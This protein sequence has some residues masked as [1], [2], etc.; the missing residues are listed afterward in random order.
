MSVCHHQNY[1]NAEKEVCW[2]NTAEIYHL[3][4]LS[5]RVWQVFVLINFTVTTCIVINKLSISFIDS[6]VDLLYNNTIET[7]SCWRK[8]LKYFDDHE[9]SNFP[10]LKIF[11]SAK[12]FNKES[13]TDFNDYQH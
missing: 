6:T 10:N 3:S 12:R 11:F 4:L 9:F 8:P 13:K 5:V 7:P 1:N 2:S